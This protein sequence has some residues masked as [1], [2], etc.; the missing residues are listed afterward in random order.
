ME[1]VSNVISI[2]VEVY[3]NMIKVL[4]RGQEV[5]ISDISKVSL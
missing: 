3:L 5:D 2:N 1:T 4:S